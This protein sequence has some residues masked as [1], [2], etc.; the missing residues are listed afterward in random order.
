MPCHHFQRLFSDPEINHIFTDKNA[1]LNAESM[2]SNRY[3]LHFEID[4][5]GTPNQSSNLS[6]K[7]TN[8]SVN[9]IHV[10]KQGFGF[11]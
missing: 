6:G 9:I 7:P 2:R 5:I 11:T 8:I 1:E 10:G 4:D 3:K